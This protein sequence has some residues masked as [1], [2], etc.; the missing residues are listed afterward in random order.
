[1]FTIFYVRMYLIPN[2]GELRIIFNGNGWIME[3]LLHD[4]P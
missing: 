4:Q 3:F 1:M 2:L